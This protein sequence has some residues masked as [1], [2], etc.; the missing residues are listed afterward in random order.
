MN[1]II[2]DRDGVINEHG[3]DHVRSAD[4]WQAIPGSLEAIAR[5]NRAGYKVFVVT[6]Q[7]G[8][9]RQYYGVQSL[10]AIHRRMREALSTVGGHIDGLFYCPHGPWEDCGCRLPNP[11]MLTELESRL[12][13]RLDGVPMVADKLR[14]VQ[15]AMAVGARPILVKS[16]AG[17]K[18][19]EENRGL[20][21]I[22]AYKNLSAVADALLE[23]K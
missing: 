19:L 18:T 13:T 17:S 11:G 12:G 14:A 2:L 16:G 15:A 21:R 22:A 8:I 9:A 5:F 1:I 7:S 4:D 10:H 20:D 23:D 3:A 6:N